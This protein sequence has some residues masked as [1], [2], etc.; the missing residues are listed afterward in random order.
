MVV[1]LTLLTAE[2]EGYKLQDVYKVHRG[3][4]EGGCCSF[5]LVAVQR[6]DFVLHVVG[7]AK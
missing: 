4:A 5:E 7:H 1:R 2:W 6:N 3:Q